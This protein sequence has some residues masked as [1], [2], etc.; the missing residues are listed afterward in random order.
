MA[1]KLPRATCD[2]LRATCRRATCCVRRAT[3]ATCDVPVLRATCHVHVRT[4]LPVQH[5]SKS[6]V[7]ARHV[8]RAEPV[9]SALVRTRDRASGRGV[10][11]QGARDTVWSPSETT[12]EA[13]WFEPTRPSVD[14][15][16]LFGSRHSSM[17]HA[18]PSSRNDSSGAP[19]AASVISGTIRP[20]QP[21]EASSQPAKSAATRAIARRRSTGARM[22]SR[23]RGPAGRSKKCASAARHRVSLAQRMSVTTV[24][25]NSGGATCHSGH[26]SSA[27]R[28]TRSASDATPS[29]APACRPAT[30]RSSAGSTAGPPQSRC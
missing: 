13:T 3:T 1:E 9:R 12:R 8:A 22:R 6:H 19:L 16:V 11:R 18:S 26:G 15:Q 28:M 25:S 5:A 21:S 2:V 29:S 27:S 14:R 10:P 4:C 17:R 24:C 7:R 20:R 23:C 30:R